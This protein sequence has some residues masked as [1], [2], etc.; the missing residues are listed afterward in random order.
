[1]EL[2]LFD[3]NLGNDGGFWIQLLGITCKDQDRSFFYLE[4]DKGVWKIQLLWLQK[5]CWVLDEE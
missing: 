1:M 5:N 3:L 2:H 4:Y